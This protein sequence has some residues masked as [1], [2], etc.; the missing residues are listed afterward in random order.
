MGNVSSLKGEGRQRL[1]EMLSDGEL[2]VLSF[3]RRRVERRTQ[4][5][6]IALWHISHPFFWGRGSEER[7]TGQTRLVSLSHVRGSSCP[8][9]YSSVRERTAHS[10]LHRQYIY[11]S[12]FTTRCGG[13]YVDGSA[14]SHVSV[15]KREARP[16]ESCSSSWKRPQREVT[17]SSPGAS[18]S[19]QPAS[20]TDKRRRRPRDA[21]CRWAS[22][23]SKQPQTAHQHVSSLSFSHAGAGRS[24]L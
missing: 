8:V 1:W 2:F 15:G 24:G 23:E 18:A 5:S 17:R 9:N 10:T 11:R 12:A 21:T 13:I 7:T 4:G 6:I 3:F 19:V 16:Y 22:A 14:S 20:S